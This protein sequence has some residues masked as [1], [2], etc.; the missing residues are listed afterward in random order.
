[1][2]ALA[3]AKH[4]PA[5]F[6]AAGNRPKPFRV[7][8]QIRHWETGQCM[9]FDDTYPH[10]VWNET[11]ERR[12]VLFLD[13]QRPLAW[14]GRIFNKAVLQLIRWSPFIQDARRNHRAWEEGLER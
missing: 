14:P 9:V 1:M 10:Q 3:A 11:D 13:I 8:D 6:M 2:A 4:L 12:V 7:G 5:P